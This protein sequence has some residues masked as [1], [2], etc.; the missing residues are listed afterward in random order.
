MQSELLVPILLKMEVKPILNLSLA[1]PELFDEN[2]WR[3]LCKSKLSS[4]WDHYSF[5]SLTDRKRFAQ[6]AIRKSLLKAPTVEAQ[7]WFALLNQR[8]DL[9]EVLCREHAQKVRRV[10]L[11]LC[12]EEHMYFNRPMINFT[13]TRLGHML[14]DREQTIANFGVDKGS[15]WL[16]DQVRMFSLLGQDA[17]YDDWARRSNFETNDAKSLF[18][19]KLLEEDSKEMWFLI[20]SLTREETILARMIEKINGSE[21]APSTKRNILCNLYRGNHLELALRY[22]AKYEVRLDLG[23]LLSCLTDYYLNSGDDRGLYCSLLK[24]EERGLL[25]PGKHQSKIFKLELEEVLV[26][27]QRNSVSVRV[28]PD[29]SRPLIPC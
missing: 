27:L 26:I 2:T 4:D 28:S 17:I 12:R 3:M 7:I 15:L 6:I 25:L 23:M 1:L 5:L 24:L 16:A 13:L 22:E 8:K 9:I 18:V 20:Y 19:E 14:T 10:C 11:A 29:L 21:M